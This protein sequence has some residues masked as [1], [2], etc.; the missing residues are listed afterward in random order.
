MGEIELRSI[1]VKLVRKG[2]VISFTLIYLSILCS[3]SR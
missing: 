1:E 3:E 2:N